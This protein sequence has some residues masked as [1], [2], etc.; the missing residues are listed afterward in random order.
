VALG[1]ALLAKP[2]ILILDEALSGVEIILEKYILN[3]IDAHYP[4]MTKVYVSHRVDSESRYDYRI[5]I[6]SGNLSVLNE[7][8]A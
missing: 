7:T 8:T 5:L 6:G 1:S 3:E 4:S 2:A